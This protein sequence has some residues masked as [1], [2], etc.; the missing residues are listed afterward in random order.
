MDWIAG[1]DPWMVLGDFNS[2]L[3]ADDK[4]GGNLIKNHETEDFVDCVSRLELVDMQSVG[5]SFAWFIGRVCSKLDRVLINNA[6]LSYNV[7]VFTEFLVPGCISDH[8]CCIIS[9]DNLVVNI[10]KK[11]SSSLICGPSMRIFE[12]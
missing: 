11:V 6:W 7:T 10:N 5:C 2:Y 3:S 8:S 1:S 4:Q 9:L 12:L